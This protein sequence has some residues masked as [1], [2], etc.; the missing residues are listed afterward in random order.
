LEN[1]LTSLTATHP[2]A[3]TAPTG[4][5]SG[6]ALDL[7]LSDIRRRRQE[8]EQQRFISPDIIQRF[9]E[10]GVYRALVPTALGGERS[11]RTSSAS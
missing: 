6:A 5:D 1:P 7:L 2:A 3:S 8:F 4:L 11:R 10:I 9:K